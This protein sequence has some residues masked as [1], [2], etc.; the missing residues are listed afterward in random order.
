MKWKNEFLIVDIRKNGK[1]NIVLS[2]HPT[3]KDAEKGLERIEELCGIDV[4]VAI[5]KKVKT[6]SIKK[7]NQ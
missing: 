5:C 7:Q 3:I 2:E 1:A 6:K 4:N